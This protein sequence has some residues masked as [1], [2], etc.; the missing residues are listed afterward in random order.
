VVVF[1]HNCNSTQ[2]RHF[3]LRDELEYSFAPFEQLQV[4]YGGALLIFRIIIKIIEFD[5]D[6]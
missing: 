2:E 3:E 1:A 4:G 5:I 6:V